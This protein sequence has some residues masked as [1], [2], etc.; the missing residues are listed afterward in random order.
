MKIFTALVVLLAT[1]CLLGATVAKD[2]Q[3][4]ELLEFSSFLYGWSLTQCVLHTHLG[5]ITR[6]VTQQVD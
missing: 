1:L 3:K 4:P 6:H 5:C 2:V